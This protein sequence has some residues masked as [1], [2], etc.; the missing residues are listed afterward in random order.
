MFN[1]LTTGALPRLAAV[2]ALASVPLMAV[3]FGAL[4]P[5][6]YLNDYT[7]AVNFA[8]K[9]QIESYCA[10]VEKQTGA[11]IALVIL[12]TLA[13]EPVEDV[14]NT[15]YRKWGVGAKGKNEGVLL[16][17][18]VKDKRSRLE[19]GYGLEPVLPDGFSGSVLRAMRPALRQNDY[20]AA[21]LSAAHEL[22]TRIAQAKGVTLTERIARPAQVREPDGGGGF[23]WWLIIGGIAVLFF[24]INSSKGGGG[25]GGSRGGGGG[26]S[27]L[28]WM[29]F[30]ALN[31]G[32]RGGG[33]S[34]GGGGGG[35]FGGDSGGGGFGGFGG[36]DSGGGGASSDW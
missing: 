35:G 10:A 29:I 24:I 22:G 18:V 9:T 19:V 17:L 25:I 2:L 5:Q 27:W 32:G 33:Y 34:G 7:G 14:A 31:G 1:N 23:P 16:L 11:Q 20:S 26:G 12:D 13:G 30:G 4:K 36:G 6:G 28:P 21:M 8:A 15:L 3:D